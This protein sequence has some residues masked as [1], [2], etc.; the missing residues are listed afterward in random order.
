[1][2]LRH[3]LATAAFFVAFAL[4]SLDVSV[5]L[6]VKGKVTCLDCEQGHDL[7]GIKV[8]VKC[9][10]VKKASAATTDNDG[11]FDSGAEEASPNGATNENGGSTAAAPLNCLAKVL[12]GPEQLYASRDRVV[13]KVVEARGRDGAASYALSAPLAVST[14]CPPGRECGAGSTVGSSLT[15]DLPLPKEWG[16]APSSYYIPFYPIIGIP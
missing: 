14:A 3:R 12:G 7:S 5:C 1:M 15:V 10:G 2:A 4:A 16:L 8:M 6:V 11:Y 13:A 9:D